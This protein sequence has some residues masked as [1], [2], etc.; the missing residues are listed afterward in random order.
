MAKFI[1]VLKYFRNYWKISIFSIA[2]MS[3]FEMIDLVCA[4]RDRANSQRA[5]R[6]TARSGRSKRGEY[7][8]ANRQKMFKRINLLR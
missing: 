4:L 5:I 6:A 7:G 2:M 1:D 8:S 3:L